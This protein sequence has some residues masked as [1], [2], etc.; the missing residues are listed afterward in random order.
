MSDHN[1]VTR[2]LGSDGSNASAKALQ[3]VAAERSL[4]EPRGIALARD[5]L[6][7]S[8]VVLIRSAGLLNSD[9]V[10]RGRWMLL[11]WTRV[12]SH[13]PPQAVNP[14]ERDF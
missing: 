1:A 6:D 8:T 13:T 12:R 14:L 10:V 4:P 11:N 3:A 7:D 5:F 2:T 9:T